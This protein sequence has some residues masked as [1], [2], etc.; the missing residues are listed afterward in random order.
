MHHR[1]ETTGPPQN[2]LEHALFLHEILMTHHET[3]DDESELNLSTASAHGVATV[4][5]NV[6]MPVLMKMATTI[7][8]RKSVI[9]KCINCRNF[10]V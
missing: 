2:L 9:K 8:S 4:L 5:S 7:A 1:Q 6:D 3:T 10:E